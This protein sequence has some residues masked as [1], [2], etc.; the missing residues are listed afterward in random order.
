MPNTNPTDGRL[1]PVVIAPDFYG[2]F[3]LKPQAPQ[4]L[5]QCNIAGTVNYDFFALAGLST[6]A[7]TVAW[8][9]RQSGSAL[10]NGLYLQAVCI[11]LKGWRNS[12][13]FTLVPVAG[14]CDVGTLLN[15]PIAPVV[16]NRVCWWWPALTA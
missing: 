13:S 3:V 12:M 15:C 11:E 1:S 7:F 6:Y 9:N 16:G 14:Y 4:R 5:R 2:F 10:M 8:I